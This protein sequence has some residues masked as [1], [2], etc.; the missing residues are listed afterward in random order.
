MMAHTA[1]TMLLHPQPVVR[2]LTALGNGFVAHL[3]NHALRAKLD[4]GRLDAAEGSLSSDIVLTPH[5]RYT[6]PTVHGRSRA[7]QFWESSP[8]TVGTLLRW[9]VQAAGLASRPFAEG[10]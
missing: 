6:L 7:G 2:V 8:F 1:E 4:A 3:H 5:S 9:Q 10:V